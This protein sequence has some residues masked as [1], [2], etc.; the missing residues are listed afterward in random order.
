LPAGDDDSHDYLDLGE[1]VVDDDHDHVEH[2]DHDH[3][4]HLANHDDVDD[5]AAACNHNLNHGYFYDRKW[6][7][8]AG[9]RKRRFRVGWRRRVR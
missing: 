7:R 6:R 9:R 4:E 5:H 2:P 3:V 8:R 1:H